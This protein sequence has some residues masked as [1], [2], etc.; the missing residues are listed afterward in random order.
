MSLHMTAVGL[1]APLVLAVTLLLTGCGRTLVFAEQ[2]GFNLSIVAKPSEA[3][4]L[5]VNIGLDRTVA[6]LV[7]PIHENTP[8]GRVDGEG[9]NVF[10]GFNAH[11]DSATQPLAGNL[12][13]RTQFASGQAATAIAG[14]PDAVARVVNVTDVPLGALTP[15][16]IRPLVLPLRRKI[17]DLSD[18]KIFE[19]A[20]VLGLV[21]PNEILSRSQA[22]SRIGNELDLARQ[23]VSDFG[24]FKEAVDKVAGK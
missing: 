14:D 21:K 1:P 18:P 19:L 2:T 4:P 13:I 22:E 20:R 7:P 11:Y 10:A 17:R 24:K 8:Q 15:D 9:V 23:S 3:T 6:S 12:R 16:S 5:K